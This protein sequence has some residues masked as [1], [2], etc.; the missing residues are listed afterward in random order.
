MIR[1]RTFIVIYCVF[2]SLFSVA[3]TYAQTAQEIAQKSFRSTV[4]LVMEDVN[5]QALTLGSGFFVKKGEIA[6][7]LHVVKGATGGYAKLIDEKTKYEIE[8]ITAVDPKRDLVILKIANIRSPVL[9][10][11]NSDAVQIGEPIFVVGNPKGLEGTFS[12]GIISGIRKIGADKILQITAPISPGSSGGPVLNQAGK[13][14]G[15]SVATFKGGQNL[16]FAI[17]SSYLKNLLAKIGTV[18]PL[19]K[20]KQGESQRSILSDIGGNSTEGVTVEN[21]IWDNDYDNSYVRIQGFTFSI[22]NHL[23]SAISNIFA[24]II[25]YDRNGSPLDVIPLK[26]S[27]LIPAK[28][29]KRASSSADYSIKKMTTSYKRISKFKDSPDTKV[30]FRILDFEIVD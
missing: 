20:S 19:T 8:G 5:G 21:F 30:E 12:Q 6:T 26:F 16:N 25:F 9:S 29:A 14:I 28:L 3:L 13:V 11:G 27:N 18:N 23:R 22:R 2:F 17:P 24:L 15:I 10:L 7:N 1:T 4:L